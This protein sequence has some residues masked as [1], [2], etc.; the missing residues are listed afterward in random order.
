MSTFQNLF[1]ERPEPAVHG[2]LPPALAAL[3]LQGVCV[4]LAWMISGLTPVLPWT[5]QAGLLAGAAS[6]ALAMAPWWIVINAL[7]VPALELAQSAALPAALWLGGFVLLAL[8][9]WGVART[10]VPLFLSSDAAAQ[11][12]AQLLGEAGTQRFAD[13]GCG[14]GRLL[15][16]LLRLQPRLKGYG[17]EYA[18]LPW[19]I[20]RLRLLA[21][22]LS[23]RIACGSLWNQHLGGFD[24]VYAYLSPVPMAALWDKARREMPEGSLFISNSF[25][26]P[27]VKAEREVVLDD[28]WGGRLHV[29]RIRR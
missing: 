29:Y 25:A 15:A 8:V 6:F 23:C 27:G 21:G 28:G 7:F 26:V 2:S 22:G 5:V 3:L 18:P 17:I 19:L 16:R 10:R 11:A 24:A 9:F 13:L 12:L 20:A 14:D 4:S 1:A